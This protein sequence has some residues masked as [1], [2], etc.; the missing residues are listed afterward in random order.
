MGYNEGGEYHILGNIFRT[1]TTIHRVKWFTNSSEGKKPYVHVY[2]I[3]L[4]ENGMPTGTLLFSQKNVP[5]NDDVWT[6]FELPERVNAPR[7]FM[8][9]LSSDETYI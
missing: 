1:P 5:T 6:T 2:I 3:D 9:A 8:L 4:D 7:G